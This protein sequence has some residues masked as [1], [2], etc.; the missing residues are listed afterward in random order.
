[1]IKVDEKTY[2]IHKKDEKSGCVSKYIVYNTTKKE[3]ITS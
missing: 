1:M 3:I 2:S